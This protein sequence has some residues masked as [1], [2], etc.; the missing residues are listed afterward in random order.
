[1]KMKKKPN[2]KFNNNQMT[3]RTNYISRMKKLNK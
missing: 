1:M 3:I 2:N